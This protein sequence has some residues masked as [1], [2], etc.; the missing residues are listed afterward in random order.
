[1]GIHE[2]FG[3]PG[4]DAKVIECLGPVSIHRL[5]FACRSLSGRA[6]LYLPER[7]PGCD[8]VALE[9]LAY[10]CLQKYE[11]PL[12]ACDREGILDDLFLLTLIGRP[13]GHGAVAPEANLLD[14]AVERKLRVVIPLLRMRGY[15]LELLDVY[16]FESL[17]QR[18]REEE[19]RSYLE[20]GM[21]PDIRANAGRSVLQVA[22]AWQ[23]RRVTPALIEW[24]ADVNQSSGF[25][26]WTAL[27][28]SAHVGWEHGC[29]LLLAANARVN[30]AQNSQGRTALDIAR[31]RKHAGVEALLSGREGD[32][33]AP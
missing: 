2:L 8:P 11:T 7:L 26:D 3:Y 29:R 4:L 33:A 27:M 15:T 17:V 18:D 21:S 10:E 22:I 25:G 16:S 19:V 23:A 24:K 13:K 6:L 20:A 30:D 32:L 14:L 28:W 9:T 12:T 1:M 31:H 5:C